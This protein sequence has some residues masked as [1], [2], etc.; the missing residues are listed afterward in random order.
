MAITL[1]RRFVC[2]SIDNF[3]LFEKIE[4]IPE[5]ITHTLFE[6][7]WRSEVK[8]SLIGAKVGRTFGD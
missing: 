3:R 5:R 7:R 8:I 6:A 1:V 2:C 4:L